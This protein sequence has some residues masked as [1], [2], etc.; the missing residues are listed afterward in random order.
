M[1]TDFQ[2]SFTEFLVKRKVDIQARRYTT[3]WNVYAQ[4]RY[5]PELSEANC[6]AI[7]SHAIYTVSRKEG[8]SIF[9]PLTLPNI[10]KFL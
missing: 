5:A 6:R 1:P 7:L 4:N 8:A 9:W 2:N 3:L 10:F